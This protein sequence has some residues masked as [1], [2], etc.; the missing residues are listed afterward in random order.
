MA[1]I[2]LILLSFL[3]TSAFAV[4]TSTPATIIVRQAENSNVVELVSSDAKLSETE[5]QA[6]ASTAEFSPLAMDELDRETG[7][8]SFYFRWNWSYGYYRPWAFNYYG[9]SYALSY[10]WNW[11][12][13]NYYCYYP[14]W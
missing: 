4:E 13:Y 10:A 2:A 7:V 8:A 1:K 12:G 3:S 9:Y 14:R 11:Y 5:A 6:L